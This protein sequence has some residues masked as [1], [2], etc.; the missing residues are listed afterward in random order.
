[1]AI[2]DLDMIFKYIV[3]GCEG[4]A[5]DSRVLTESVHD[6]RHNF[7]MPPLGNLWTNRS[8][9]HATNTRSTN[10]INFLKDLIYF[11]VF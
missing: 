4:A 9:L 8:N 10:I 3:V 11:L 6:S 2:F 5:H 1:M 7:P